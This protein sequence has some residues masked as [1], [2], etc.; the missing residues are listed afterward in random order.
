MFDMMDNSGKKAL[1][2]ELYSLLAD[3]FTMSFRAQACHWNVR[4][5]D[6]H[7]FHEFFAMIYGDV[8][9]S[10][11]PTAE[12]IRKLGFDA[13]L[14]LS[15]MC[16]T[17]MIRDESFTGNPMDMTAA[18]LSA[19]DVIIARIFSAFAVAAECNE[20]AIANYLAD[21]LDKHQ[22]WAWQMKSILNIDGQVAPGK[23]E[24]DLLLT[25]PAMQSVEDQPFELTRPVRFSERTELALL[26]RVDA[27]NKVAQPGKRTTL[28]TIKAVYR[29]GATSFST[30]S[31][32]HMSRDQWAMARVDGHLSALRTGKVKSGYRALDRDL[33]P[34]GHPLADTSSVTASAS[35]KASLTVTLKDPA[36]YASAEEAIVALAEFSGQGY[37]IVPA[38]RATWKRAVNDGE[39]AYDRA[40]ELATRLYDSRDSDLLPNL[41]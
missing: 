36:E 40:Y 30:S 37:E 19:N 17:T 35:V 21:R 4:G 8:E 29:R 1:A 3:S 41:D 13:P 24:A 5:E 9:S 34:N 27:H 22:K 26:N 28:S 2:G 38:L 23:L 32:S 14:N 18:L 12:N 20:Q 39:K 6:F 7:Q 16:A 15:D 31:S 25:A 10:I 33:L 11:D